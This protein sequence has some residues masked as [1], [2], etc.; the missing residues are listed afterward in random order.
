MFNFGL[1]DRT[2]NVMNM[3]RFLRRAKSPYDVLKESQKNKTMHERF[4]K[5]NDKFKKLLV[6]AIEL[7]K[8]SNKVLFFKFG[9]EISMAADLSNKL[10]HLFPKKIV[11]VAYVS[12]LKVNISMRGLGARD[13]LLESIKGLENAT[14]G[15]HKFAVGARVMVKDLDKFKENIEELV[16]KK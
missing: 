6:D 16:D 5:I 11:I 13:L 2:T 1:K 3:L 9:G 15:G 12:E 4:K 10:I 8:Q 14:G 7:G